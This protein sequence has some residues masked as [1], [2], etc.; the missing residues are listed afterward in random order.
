[1]RCEPNTPLAQALIKE[2]VSSGSIP[3]LTSRGDVVVDTV[4]AGAVRVLKLVPKL[5][6]DRDR[7]RAE[8]WG[9]ARRGSQ[10]CLVR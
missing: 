2:M 3:H 10:R 7:I 1:M 4:P 8:G 6:V 9:K 5:R